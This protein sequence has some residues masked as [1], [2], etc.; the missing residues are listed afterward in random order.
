MNGS[1]FARTLK[2]NPELRHDFEAWLKEVQEN[3]RHELESAGL[4][5]AIFRAQGKVGV[6]YDLKNNLEQMM[7]LPAEENGVSRRD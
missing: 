2:Q 3:Y 4:D 6:I 5:I 1:L 7:N